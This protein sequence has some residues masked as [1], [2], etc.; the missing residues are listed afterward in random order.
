MN[1][2]IPVA[3][4]SFRVEVDGDGIAHIVFGPAG[5][6][7]VTDIAGHAVLGTIWH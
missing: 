3:T 2:E 4:K 1:R 5:G 7:P 6:M